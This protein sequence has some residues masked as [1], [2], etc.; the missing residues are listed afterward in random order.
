VIIRWKDEIAASASAADNFTEEPLTSDM[1][2]DGRGKVMMDRESILR[3]LKGILL[4][5][6]A[7]SVEMMCLSVAFCGIS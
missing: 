2:G 6:W 3:I 4:S 7:Q 5:R 1:D